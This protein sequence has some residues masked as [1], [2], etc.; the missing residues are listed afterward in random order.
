LVGVDASWIYKQNITGHHSKRSLRAVRDVRN[1]LST[2]IKNIQCYGGPY[3]SEAAQEYLHYERDW[4]V[5]RN[6]NNDECHE[7][8]TNKNPCSSLDRNWQSKDAATGDSR[9]ATRN[10]HGS[11]NRDCESEYT[12][13]RYENEA[14][15]DRRSCIDAG[16]PE[17]PSHTSAQLKG[18]VQIE[19]S[20]TAKKGT[21]S[22]PRDQDDRTRSEIG[23]E[24]CCG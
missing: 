1:H 11:G 6:G 16:D 20:N 4:S 10:D 12:H 21:G 5:R 15:R 14:Q 18:L 22:H 23:A 8:T 9:V 3:I 2:Y 13:P 7:C 24:N 19:R 17:R